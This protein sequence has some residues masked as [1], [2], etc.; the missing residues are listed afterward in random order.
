MQNNKL[1]LYAN[2]TSKEAK[3][4][5][6]QLKELLHRE[7]ALLDEKQ[8]QNYDAALKKSEISKLILQDMYDTYEEVLA[9]R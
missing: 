8:A 6:I 2:D 4:K 3:Q 9:R 7:Q 1:I 5:F